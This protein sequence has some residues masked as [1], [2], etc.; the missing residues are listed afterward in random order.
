[1]SF[2]DMLGSALWFILPAYIANAAPVLFGG[3]TPIDRGKKFIDGRPILGPG[4]T[5]RGFTAGLLCGT[6]VGFVQTIAAAQHHHSRVLVGALLATGALVGDLLG[7]FIKR[8]LGF[9]RGKAAPGLDQLGFLAFALLFAS[10]LTVP[11][12]EIFILLL[13]ITPPIHLSTNYCGYK[14]GLK[15]KPY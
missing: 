14:L 1:M 6:A 15:K 3:G 13:L 4:K 5:I 12:F 8:R 10:P 7:S 11:A 2:L 9:P